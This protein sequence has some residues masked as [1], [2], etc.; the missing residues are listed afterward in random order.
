M[1]FG[2]C[3]FPKLKIY[4]EPRQW[5]LTVMKYT[6][7]WLALM[8][9]LP[10]CTLISSTRDEPALS[11]I[12]PT[13]SVETWESLDSVALVSPP[14]RDLVALTNS[15]HPGTVGRVAQSEPTEYAVGDIASFWYKELDSDENRECQAELA[16]R[17]DSLNMWIEVGQ[18]FDA[19]RIS[20][21][22]GVIE[23]LILP[24]NRALF[25]TEWQ[26]GIDG[27]NR[28]NILHLKKVGG[29]GAAYYWSGDE[30]VTGINPFSNQRELLYV[31]LKHADIGSEA[32]FVAI[33]H[34]LQHLIHWHIDANEDAWLNEGLSE[35]ASSA[36]GFTINRASSYVNQTDIQL[37]TLSHELD[38]IG[39]HYASAALFSIYFRDRFG[40]QATSDLV[41]QQANGIN[42]FDDTLNALGSGLSFNDLFADWLVTNYLAGAGLS[43]GIYQYADL[44]MPAVKTNHLGRLPAAQISTVNQYGAD[45][46]RITNDEPVTLAFT[47]TQQVDL[48]DTQP[49][50]GRFFWISSPADESNMTLTRTFDL[51]GLSSATLTYW[52]WY[53][54]EPGWD[55]GYTAISADGGESWELLETTS[56]SSDNPQGNSM[57]PAIT[58]NSGGGSEPEWVQESAD[59]TPYVG[60]SVQIRFQYVT[61]GAVHLG[62]VALDDITI[63]ELGYLDD[64]ERDDSGW[65]HQ[66]FTRATGT[67]PASFLVQSIQQTTAGL[68]IRR[69]RL[70]E[71]QQGKWT[72]PLNKQL[73]EVI[74]IISGITPVSR[75]PSAYAFEVTQAGKQQ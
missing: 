7:V 75:H 11:L 2:R 16:Y 70:D 54:I 26:P 52:A 69:L 13:P 4:S 23:S 42:G 33:A 43:Q 51:S 15:L 62:G 34:E 20:E 53:E 35:L 41:S 28:I 57:G 73:N 47:G 44:K 39:A 63:P 58:G 50:S 48:A 60:Q 49:K 74:L 31:S 30:Y 21:A 9:A 67:L 40:D 45:Y 1:R 56:A 24:T 59:L 12:I 46:Y 25:G 71:N 3:R 18:R 32:Y 65:E 29:I 64:A 19:D 22:A 38:V 36:N 68:E 27:D 72:F 66:G 14:P 5:G 10:A 37:T 17:S 6:L 8:L 55:Y 61:D